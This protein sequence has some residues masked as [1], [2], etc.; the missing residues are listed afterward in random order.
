MIKV[1][2]K[3]F[4][5]QC[6]LSSALYCECL[7]LFLAPSM[8]VQNCHLPSTECVCVF[9]QP[10][11][12]V[13]TRWMMTGV[14]PCCSP[15]ALTTAPPSPGALVICTSTSDRRLS[16]QS[17]FHNLAVNRDLMMHIL[18]WRSRPL[19][20]C[21]YGQISIWLNWCLEA[22]AQKW[23]TQNGVT[24]LKRL[25]TSASEADVIRLPRP[26]VIGFL[27][28]GGSSVP[29]EDMTLECRR[30]LALFLVS[31]HTA[32]MPPPSHPPLT[33]AIQ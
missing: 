20:D 1:P 18:D 16:F 6:K 21:Y 31:S 17:V 19:R 8:S 3:I 23:G 12:T 14:S 25:G 10:P 33:K 9:V 24:D 27:S 30:R 7:I 28:D 4:K 26:L 29:G 32:L 15:I 22:D 2:N 13:N 5:C 11:C